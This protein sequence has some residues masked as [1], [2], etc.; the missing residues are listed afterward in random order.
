MIGAAAAALFVLIA[1]WALIYG[2]MATSTKL[3]C[4]IA[5]HGDAVLAGV[6][7]ARPLS[8]TGIEQVRWVAREAASKAVQ[9]STVLHSGILRAQQTA[10][11]YGRYLNPPL[12]IRQISGLLPDDDPALGKA[13]LEAAEAP[14]MLVGHLPYMGRLAELLAKTNNDHAMIDFPTA[15]L[16]CFSRTK[17]GWELEWRVVPQLL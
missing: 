11:I 5:R 4:Y 8:N 2:A 17:S 9:V 13:E 15:T 12:G 16:V 14:I 7:P 1:D 6:D 10:E 3:Q